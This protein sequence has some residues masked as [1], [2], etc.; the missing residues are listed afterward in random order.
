MRTPQLIALL[1]LTLAT[2]LVAAPQ[3]GAIIGG[4]P[5]DK[6]FPFMASLQTK[7]PAGAPF[8]HWCGASLIAPQW[9]ITAAHCVSGAE[10][11]PEL[12]QVRVGSADNTT[13]GDVRAVSKIVTNPGYRSWPDDGTDRYEA[14]MALVKLSAPVPDRPVHIGLFTEPQPVSAI[15]WGR[16][17]ADAACTTYAN[18]TRLQQLDTEILPQKPCSV[19]AAPS[20]NPTYELC[21]GSVTKKANPAGGDSGGPALAKAGGQWLLLGVCSHGPAVSDKF[22]QTEP[23]TAPTF[24]TSVPAHL[25]WVLKTITT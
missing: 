18:P 24:Y 16:V 1:T 4:Q 20:Q 10:D 25:G 8:G 9:V 6:P 17:C 5:A 15:G 11:H 13:G 23:G 2:G 21:V 19:P 22:P 14:D 7:Y 12:Y 3:A